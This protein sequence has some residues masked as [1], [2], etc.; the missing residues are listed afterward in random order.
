M[1]GTVFL[2]S[3]E[4]GCQRKGATRIPHKNK[5]APLPSDGADDQHTAVG[6]RP[7]TAGG[8]IPRDGGSPKLDADGTRSKH[9]D[10]R[11]GG[12]LAK[13]NANSAL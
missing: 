2:A 1:L 4:N 7:Q 13:A 10:E 9:R 5:G 6:A 3:G 12:I 11:L 8:T